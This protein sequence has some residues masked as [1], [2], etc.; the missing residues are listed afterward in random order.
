MNNSINNATTMRDITQ[1]MNYGVSLETLLEKIHLI[2]EN[3]ST[4][5]N[6]LKELINGCILFL[7]SD[8]CLEKLCY[9]VFLTALI[10]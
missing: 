3:I 4:N 9:T 8:T 1:I 10:D 2:N 7:C 6:M 5:V